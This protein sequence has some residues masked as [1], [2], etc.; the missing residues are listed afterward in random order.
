MPPIPKNVCK[1]PLLFA[2]FSHI[3]QT[4]GLTRKSV[5]HKAGYC[6]WGLRQLG[7]ARFQPRLRSFMDLAEAAGLEVKLVPKGG[8]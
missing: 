1:N 7:N 5:F 3:D 8:E 6:G 4:P 2:L